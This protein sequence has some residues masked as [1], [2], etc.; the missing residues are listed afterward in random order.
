MKT[1]LFATTALLTAISLSHSA[2]A[3]CGDS[4]SDPG[5]T[6]DDGNT[7]NGDG[8]SSSCQQEPG[9]ECQEAVFDLAFDED[10]TS[11]G[12]SPN[13]T[14]SGDRRTVTQS[15]NSRPGVYMSTLPAVGTSISMSLAVNTT[16]DDDFIGFV[17]G[18]DQGEKSSA[19]ANW[20]LVDWKQLNQNIGGCTSRV[21]M[22][23]SIIDGPI[24][25][26]NN[27]WCHTGSVNEIA[28]ANTL[29]STGWRDNIDHV[30]DV[31]YNLDSLQI[32]VDGVLQF[33]LVGDFPAGN[34]GFYTFS[35]E[36]NEFTL[37]GPTAG[38]LS[39]IHI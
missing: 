21:G 39:L 22:A 36:A 24:S 26:D 28:R 27:M 31:E 20:L 25:G 38:E 12:S 3:A 13:W 6:C 8:C 34:F 10:L 35:Q 11:S 33:D 7:A 18:Y 23:L 17:I 14:L 30:I 15:V 9:F 16:G 5:E 4:T 1:Q 32:W 19:S 2:Q 37:V 29:G